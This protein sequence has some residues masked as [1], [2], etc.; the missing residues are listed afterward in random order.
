[1]QWGQIIF[2]FLQ[3]W[4]QRLAL[5]FRVGDVCERCT[6]SLLTAIASS[7]TATRVLYLSFLFDAAMRDAVHIKSAL[8][9]RGK[10]LSRIGQWSMRD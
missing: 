4:C 6:C 5:V 3:A 7:L 9:K 2:F 8:E 1:M 10:L